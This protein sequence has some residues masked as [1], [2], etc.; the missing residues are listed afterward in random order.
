M[1]WKIGNDQR[2]L[3]LLTLQCVP[4]PEFASKMDSV[5]IMVGL[6]LFSDDELKNEVKRIP[7]QKIVTL[8]KQVDFQCILLHDSRTPPPSPAISKYVSLNKF[9]ANIVSRVTIFLMSLSPSDSYRVSIPGKD[10]SHEIGAM[11]SVDSTKR[12][13]FSDIT[14]VASPKGDSTQAPV[15]FFAHKVIL[16]A[17][18]PI[19]ARMFEHEMQESLNNRIEIDDIDPEVIKEMLVYIYS[20]RVPKINE[21]AGDLLYVADKYQLDELKAL[22]EQHLTYSL[23]VDNASRI[24]QL[25]FTHNAPQLKKNAVQFIAKN[26]AE[27]RATEEWAEVKQGNEILDELIEA[28]QEPPAKRPKTD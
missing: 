13:K 18:S 10:T 23:Q 20:S 6:R 21:M 4:N 25:A 5:Q 9:G 19:F 12:S 15:E 17:R 26:T 8:T 1:K 2:S 27:V 16:A 3:L 7:P 11:L 24:I 28:M 14:L 22:C